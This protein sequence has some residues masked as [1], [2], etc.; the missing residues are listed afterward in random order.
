MRIL[1]KFLKK[2]KP[3]PIKTL[4]VEKKNEVD[5]STL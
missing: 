1:R 3:I 5:R 2:K 4:F